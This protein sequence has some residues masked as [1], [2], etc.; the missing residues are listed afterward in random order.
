MATLA[1]VQQDSQYLA[2]REPKL[3][4]LK[5]VLAEHFQRFDKAERST[6][7]I[8]FVN[9]R[10]TVQQIVEELNH[11]RE[12][13]DVIRC[14]PTVSSLSPMHIFCNERLGGF[15]TQLFLACAE[16]MVVS[17]WGL[18]EAAGGTGTGTGTWIGA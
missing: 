18:A 9:L 15:F 8:V 7:A 2:K 12:F 13:S 17:R 11:S 10:T 5:E 3:A 14:C 1:R 16:Q 6:R 4:K